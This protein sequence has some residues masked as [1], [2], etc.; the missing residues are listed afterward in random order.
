MIQ[1]KEYVD[2]LINSRRYDIIV[3]ESTK[4]FIK[5]KGVNIKISDNNYNKDEFQNDFNIFKDNFDNI[6]SKIFAYNNHPEIWGKDKDGTI[7]DE[8]D[9]LKLMK[10]YLHLDV[11]IYKP[12]SHKFEIWYNNEN[13]NGDKY[14]I[15]E[16]HS[17][18]AHIIIKDGKATVYNTGL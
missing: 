15:F 5:F 16:G 17:V 1:I 13:H 10:K 14:K 12:S 3:N 6:E 2:T 8:K 11:I 18:W 9:F 7:L 4:Q